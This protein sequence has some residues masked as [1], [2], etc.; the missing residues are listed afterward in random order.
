MDTNSNIR[1]L[2]ERIEYMR[3]WRNDMERS[4]FFQREEYRRLLHK[5]GRKEKKYMSVE[6]NGDGSESVDEAEELKQWGV[7]GRT[8]VRGMYV[9]KLVFVVGVRMGLLMNVRIGDGCRR[10]G[11][12]R[13]CS[14]L[15]GLLS[16]RCRGWTT[17]IFPLRSLSWISGVIGCVSVW[18]LSWC[19]VRERRRS[20]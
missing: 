3:R 17:I 15:I 19:W 20:D 8:W 7:G 9:S 11:S 18:R 13:E 6:E 1:D 5:L 16:G 10:R 14:S 2:R 4:V 12:G